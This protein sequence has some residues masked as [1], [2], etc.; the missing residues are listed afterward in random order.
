MGMLIAYHWCKNPVY[1]VHNCVIHGKI[2]QLPVG[3]G[4][5]S[6]G[7]PL[8]A[9][10]TNTKGPWAKV[11]FLTRTRKAQSLPLLIPKTSAKKRWHQPALQRRTFILCKKPQLT[12]HFC[13]DL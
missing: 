9:A 8:G 4:S 5:P 1:R 13:K 3:W 7:G 6:D 12:S 11:T 10:T 2:R